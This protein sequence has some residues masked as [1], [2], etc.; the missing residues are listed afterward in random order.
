VPRS[1][2][3]GAPASAGIAHLPATSAIRPAIPGTAACRAV[4]ATGA[5]L[6]VPG[7]SAPSE[8]LASGTATPAWPPRWRA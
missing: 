7:R 6:R 2:R 3:T 5:T 8:R 4:Q 1:A